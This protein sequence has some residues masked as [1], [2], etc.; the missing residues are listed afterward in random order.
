ML[1]CSFSERTILFEKGS[2]RA[3]SA[4]SFLA[5]LTWVRSVAVRQTGA[6]QVGY[7]QVVRVIDVL[8]QVQ[9]I[10][11]RSYGPR[12]YKRSRRVTNLCCVSGNDRHIVNRATRTVG[13]VG[14]Q[15]FA[16]TSVM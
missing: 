12:P 9:A 16:L 2:M 8:L 14:G 7:G 6:T 15:A 1:K 11:G 5:V 10:P 4:C 13:A 3:V